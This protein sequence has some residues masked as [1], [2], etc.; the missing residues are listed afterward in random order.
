VKRAVV[1]GSNGSIIVD[2]TA[3]DLSEEV[4]PVKSI[5]PMLISELSL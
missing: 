4:S 1:I 3:L 5:F 2:T